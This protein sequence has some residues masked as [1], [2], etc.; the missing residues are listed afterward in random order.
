MD[1]PLNPEFPYYLVEADLTE[2]DDQFPHDSG[3]DWSRFLFFGEEREV[4]PG[5][6]LI[7]QFDC[8]S[9]IY[10]L[11]HGELEVRIAASPDEP[12]QAIAAIEPIAVIGEL[13]FL[14]EGPRTASVV[15]KQRSTVYRLT[16]GAFEE[17]RA[18]EPDV[19]WAFM[20]DI[21]RSL[22]RRA[23]GLLARQTG[24]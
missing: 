3:I 18:S 14:D 6:Y 9:T 16:R 17:M 21:A 20:L 23:R 7:R 4:A 15:G 11:T 24:L 22:S 8:D 10:V 13:G 5:E 1:F 12:G 19:A 2:L